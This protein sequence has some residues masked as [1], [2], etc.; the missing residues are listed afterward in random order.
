ML[1]RGV[2]HLP[3]CVGFGLYLDIL[4]VVKRGSEIGATGVESVV[5]WLAGV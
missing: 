2:I 3:D 5:G 4:K 1:R